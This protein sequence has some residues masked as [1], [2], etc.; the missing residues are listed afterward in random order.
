MEVLRDDKTNGWKTNF[1]HLACRP[2]GID[3][4]AARIQRGD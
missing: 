4:G 2:F 3:S 1:Q